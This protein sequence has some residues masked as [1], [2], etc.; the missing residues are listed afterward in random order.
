MIV[1]KKY[2]IVVIGAGHAGLEAA[3]S[4]SKKGLKTAIITL[5]KNDVG[6]MPCN[7][8][9]GGPA[10]G[11]VTREIDALGGMQGKAADACQIQMKILGT[12]KGP[13]VWALRG[14]IDKVKY[15]EWFLEQ[16]DKQENL[17]LI[18]DEVKNFIIEDKQIKGVSLLNKDILCGAVIV[19]SGTYMQS[20]TYR[21]NDIKN[22][23]ADGSDY[24]KYLS[25][26][27]KELGFNLIR[28]KTGTPARIKKDSIDYSVMEIDYG[29][30]TPLYFSH[31]RK[32]WN[33]NENKKEPCY[34][35]H[36]NLDTHKIIQDNIKQSAMYSGVISSI[37]PR[38]CPSIED[39][40]VKFSSRDR[41]QIFIEPESHS[42]NTMYLGGFSTSMPIDVQ[43]KMIRSLKGLENC[44]IIKYGYAIEYDAVDPTELYPY[45]MTKK[46]KGLFLAGQING[47]S[48]YEEAAGQGLIAGINAANYILNKPFLIMKR[49]NSYLG[50]MIDDI[51][52]KG[53][54]EP[55]RL[56]TSRAEHRLFLRNDNADERL[57][58]IG[59]NEGLISLELYNEY[60]ANQKLIKD[61]IE[62]LHSKT[63][64]Q[65]SELKNITAKNNATLYEFLKRPE[66][67]LDDILPYTSFSNIPNHIKEKIEINVKF[68]GYIKSQ[69]DKLNQFNNMKEYDISNIIDFK[70]IP[71]LS[72]E[73]IDKLNKIKPLTISQASRI[74]GINIEDIL[75]IKYYLDNKND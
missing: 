23:G 73:A 47:T 24:S 70:Q 37:G 13:G 33:W 22:E 59:F 62:F 68:E 74:S 40:I 71:N 11:T 6:K 12:S 21:G 27:L 66:I 18:I 69:N 64:G 5:N 28:L 2:D 52:T 63:I 31:D 41:H 49:S 65:V 4:A 42:L 72:L 7:P 1:D 34:L 46:I 19:T 35:F 38:Y 20:K 36:T 43:D 56:L 48:G 50:V 58:E 32:Y 3:F 54:T 44:K 25:K 39:K 67:Q 10:K 14:Q 8:S 9:I 17:D 60:L 45:L 55:Y 51:V 57:M 61:V 26:D 75:K 53:V 16:I 30:E 15:H 29:S